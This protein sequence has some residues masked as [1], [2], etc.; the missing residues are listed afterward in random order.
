MAP[1]DMALVRQSIDKMDDQFA[2]GLPAH[3]PVERFKRVVMTAIQSN[4]S[5]LG[6]D[7]RSMFSAA[8]K[9]AQDG[10]LP[11]GREGAL[12]PFKGQVQWMP[13]IAGIRKKVRNSGEIATWDVQA[14]YE[15]DEFEFE[16]GDDPFIKH[17]PCLKDR[18]ELVAVYSVATLKSGEKTRD[19]M[20]V[21]DIE[22]IRSL[23][24]SKNGPWS[25]PKFYAE[26][27]KKTVARRHSKVLPMSTD[28][29]DLIRRDDALYDLGAASDGSVKNVTPVAASL[30]NKMKQAVGSDDDMGNGAIEGS[31]VDH[32]EDGV[33]HDHGDAGGDP[34]A[35]ETTTE[36]DSAGDEQDHGEVSAED[37][38]DAEDRGALAFGKGRSRKS[39]PANVKAHPDLLAAWEKGFDDAKAEAD[40]GE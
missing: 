24:R 8:V 2:A 20:G 17:K 32:D 15:N 16:L 40:E 18:G 33:V 4:T 34:Q 6:C 13:M 21:D 37:R 10:L 29:D 7:R 23:S 3:I 35:D 39:P 11:D 25:N 12:V 19:V 26:M 22:S 38:Q 31:T 9:A 14:V 1:N 5:L 28:L 30:E 27:A 36:A